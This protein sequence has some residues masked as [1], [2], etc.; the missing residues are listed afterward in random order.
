MEWPAMKRPT[1][2]QELRCSMKTYGLLQRS[3]LYASV[4]L[5]GSWL[6]PF[7]VHAEEGQVTGAMIFAPADKLSEVASGAVEDTLKACLARIPAKS[8]AGQRML[9]ERTCH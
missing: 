3:V 2:G 7:F 9:A 1:R 4:L 5:L 6:S 8:T